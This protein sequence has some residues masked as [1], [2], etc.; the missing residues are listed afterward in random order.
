[1]L[2]TIYILASI[3]SYQGTIVLPH[4]PATGLVGICQTNGAMHASTTVKMTDPPALKIG[5]LVSVKEDMRRDGRRTD[6]FIE[7]IEVIGQGHPPTFV[8]VTTKTINTGRATG[9]FVTIK[10]VIQDVFRDD[11]DDRFV[12][13][14]ISDGDG[15]AFWAGAGDDGG[16]RLSNLIG[17]TVEASGIAVSGDFTARRNFGPSIV[18]TSMKSLVV[19]SKAVADLFDAPDI[20][21]IEH[22]PPSEIAFLPR[23][24]TSG[25]ILAI[26]DTKTF[27]LRREKAGDASTPSHPA[28]EGSSE[29]ADHAFTTVHLAFEGVPALG[30]FVDVVGYPESNLYTIN[31][32]RAVWRKSAAAPRSCAAETPAE[33]TM[34]RLFRDVAGISTPN[35]QLHGK[36]LKIRGVLRRLPLPD[37]P[38]N[39]ALVESDGH[40]L[41]INPGLSTHLF[42][43][44]EIGS[45]IAVTGIAVIE[46]EHW[47]P[48]LLIPR[49]LHTTLVPRGPEDIEIV[50]GPPFWTPMK[51]LALIA[52]LAVALVVALLR[53]KTIQRL[54]EERVSERT[55][56]AAELHDTIAQNLTGAAIQLETAE[57]LASDGSNKLKQILASTAKIMQVSREE[58]RDCIWDLRNQTLD[59]RRVE[60]ALR[61]TLLPHICGTRLRLRFPVN[62]VDISDRSAHAAVSIVRELVSNAIHHGRPRTVS[63]A[64]VLDGEWLKFSVTDDGVGFDAEHIAGPRDGH[65]GL[66]G[67]RERIRKLGGALD[68]KSKPGCGAKISVRLKKS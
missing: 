9:Q 19:V 68:I 5:Q 31:L 63:I 50:S 21:K 17:A 52:T 27:L 65:F 66:S 48:H 23:H 47:R 26:L 67:I 4:D 45:S 25:R 38:V 18:S 6:R 64:G 62:R 60:D 22:A 55:R 20:A 8:P 30:D 33:Y 43:R 29:R 42:D 7:E 3:F 11:I 35:A 54:S 36:L 61:R 39:T 16:S 1:M 41:E 40:F 28:F 10:G 49:T 2:S 59:E 58:L 56:L 24:R 15:L 46:K 32:A 57:V 51:F 12:F 53:N 13:A 44:M 37:D 34:A 14:S